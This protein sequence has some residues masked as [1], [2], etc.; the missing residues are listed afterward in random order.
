[1]YVHVYMRAHTHT[2]MQS[3]HVK[4]LVAVWHQHWQSI[5]DTTLAIDMTHIIRSFI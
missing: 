5:I 4:Q 3:L 2:Y 1:M